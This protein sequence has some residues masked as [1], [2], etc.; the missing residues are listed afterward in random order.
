MNASARKPTKKE[1]KDIEGK[2]LKII[3]RNLKAWGYTTHMSDDD[4]QID[5]GKGDAVLEIDFS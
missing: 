1:L 4:I 5:F 3:N 2:L